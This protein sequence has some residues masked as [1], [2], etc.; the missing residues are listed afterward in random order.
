MDERLSRT[1]YKFCPNLSPLGPTGSFL[2]PAETTRQVTFVVWE[3]P[4]FSFPVRR[5]LQY[6]RGKKWHTRLWFMLIKFEYGSLV[7]YRSQLQNKSPTTFQHETPLKHPQEGNLVFPDSV[8]SGTHEN[9]GH[10]SPPTS[11]KKLL[12]KAI[13]ELYILIT[14]LGGQLGE[15]RGYVH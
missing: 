11:T 12:L 10:R 13:E 14:W 1:L 3:L 2:I 9:Q 4:L 6:S 15:G 8:S 7:S 5:D